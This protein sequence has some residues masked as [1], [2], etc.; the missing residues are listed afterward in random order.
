MGIA[1]QA[2]SA[3]GGQIIDCIETFL[4]PKTSN[5][6]TNYSGRGNSF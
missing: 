2:T 5:M 4:N 1:T 3:T 6:A